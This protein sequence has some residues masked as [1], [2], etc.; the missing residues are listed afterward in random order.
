M[1]KRMKQ[2]ASTITQQLSRTLFL[3]KEKIKIVRKIKE[4]IIS[5]IIDKKYDKD[6][7]LKSYLN[8]VFFGN[9]TIGINEA[10]DFYFKKFVDELTLSEIAFLV[11]ILP[12]PNKFS[13]DNEKLLTIQ[14]KNKILQL[15]RDE[16]I[17]EQSDYLVALQENINLISKKERINKLLID[18]IKKKYIKENTKNIFRN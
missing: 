4:I 17:I 3:Q 11:S 14:R 15:M 12:A 2:G 7:I 18:M 13:N 5:L 6:I 1:S 16:T 10:A 8:N 9:D